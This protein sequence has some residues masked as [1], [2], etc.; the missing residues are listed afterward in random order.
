MAEA[1]FFVVEPDKLSDY[2]E[3]FI[4]GKQLDGW[5]DTDNPWDEHEKHQVT[6]PYI[7]LNKRNQMD[8]TVEEAYLLMKQFVIKQL[9]SLIIIFIHLLI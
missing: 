8:W 3:C 9:V 5:E 2:V 6:C 4:C 1:G 7:K